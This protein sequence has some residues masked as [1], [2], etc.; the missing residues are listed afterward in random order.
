MIR[1]SCVVILLTMVSSFSQDK[2]TGT[3]MPLVKFYFFYSEDCEHCEV[4][5]E[6]AFPPLLETYNLEIQPFEIGDPQNYELLTK[7]EEKYEDTD[8]DIPVIVIGK[9]LLGGEEEVKE[10]L[11]EIIQGYQDQGVEF[12]SLENR[13]D[14]SNIKRVYLAYFY[15]T[16]CEKCDR[17]TYTL[18][19][20]QSKYPN[21]VVKKFDIA[22]EEN[23]RLN[24][25]LC[26]L[27]KVPE[28]KRLTAPMIFMGEEFLIEK[29]IKMEKIVDLI[30]EYQH[31]EVEII[32]WERAKELEEKSEKNI[33]NRFKTMSILTVLFAGAI[34]GMNP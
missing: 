12:P 8:N 22:N 34:D 9:Y 20:L 4:V 27:Y 6:E 10:N 7:F 3:G 33:I 11:E 18:N 30:E 31:G 23:K 16:G 24:E 5:Q 26:E 28:K 25:A 15:K 14:T 17:A 29:G 2:V 21:L 1:L 19:Y 32:P 13:G